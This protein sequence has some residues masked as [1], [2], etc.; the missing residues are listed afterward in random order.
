MQPDDQNDND[1]DEVDPYNPFPDGVVMEFTDVLD[2]HYIPP[3][4]VKLLVEE[5]LAEAEKRGYRYIRIIHGKGISV[6]RELV[7]SIL[8][9]TDCVDSYSDAPPEAGGWGATVAELKPKR[10][11]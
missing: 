6:Q 7:R 8:E 9:R 2:L 4:Q 11:A 10:V 5:F 1:E 3:K